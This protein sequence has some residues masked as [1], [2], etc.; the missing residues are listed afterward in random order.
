MF[1]N[2]MKIKEANTSPSKLKRGSKPKDY[3]QLKHPEEMVMVYD[4][5]WKGT[6]SQLD[7]EKHSVQCLQKSG[8]E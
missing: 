8:Y 6:Q 1:Y 5:K 4:S 2:T 3:K 7:L